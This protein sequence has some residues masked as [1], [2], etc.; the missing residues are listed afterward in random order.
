MNVLHY[1]LLTNDQ[2]IMCNVKIAGHGDK[3]ANNH[4]LTL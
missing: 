3:P 2:A 1:C 4:H